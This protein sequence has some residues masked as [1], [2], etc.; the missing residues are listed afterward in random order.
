MSLLTWSNIFLCCWLLWWQQRILAVTRLRQTEI[1]E[2]MRDLYI[3]TWTLG[4]TI[5]TGGEP[6]CYKKISRLVIR[7][8]W[9]RHPDSAAAVLRGSHQLTAASPASTDVQVLSSVGCP[10]SRD[11]CSPSPGCYR[12]VVV[13]SHCCFFPLPHT[14]KQDSGFLTWC[15]MLVL[16]CKQ[17][18]EEK[19]K[20]KQH[21]KVKLL[22]TQRV[23]FIETLLHHPANLS[24]HQKSEF[25]LIWILPNLNL[26]IIQ[27]FSKERDHI[28]VWQSQINKPLSEKVLLVFLLSLK[29]PSLHF[30]K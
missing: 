17:K 10:L 18:L 2:H 1:A 14:W 6:L 19:N 26:P 30:P 12:S 21:Q 3:Q 25:F 20:T 23:C 11:S 15:S 28:T 9:K 7:K 8:S 5:Q 24:Y 13:W 22:S 16:L 29:I 4:K 27:P